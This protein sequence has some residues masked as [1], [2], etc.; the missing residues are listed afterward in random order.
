V[1]LTDALLNGLISPEKYMEL[2]KMAGQ[3]TQAP[4]AGLQL[5][6]GYGSLPQNQDVYSTR[7]HP[8][9]MIS[10]RLHMHEGQA[11]PFHL[12]AHLDG[13]MVYVFVVCNGKPVVIEDPWLM[14]PSD[15]LI[16]Q[17]RLLYG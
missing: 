2:V 6:R 10:M 12:H 15:Q 8:E 13:D 1:A 17:L 7:L 14:F 3:S 5:N 16:S 11:F 4:M 9:A